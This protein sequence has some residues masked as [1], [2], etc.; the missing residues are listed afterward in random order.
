MHT[1]AQDKHR[2][3]HFRVSTSLPWHGLLLGIVHVFMLAYN[4]SFTVRVNIGTAN[5]LSRCGARSLALSLLRYFTRIFG[6]KGQFVRLYT[7][8]LGT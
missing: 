7:L 6:V 2:H 5:D 4:D 8:C 1:R 3:T